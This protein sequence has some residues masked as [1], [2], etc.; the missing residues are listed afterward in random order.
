LKSV[1]SAPGKVILFGEHFVVYGLKAVLASIDKRVTVTS[2][3]TDNDLVSINSILGKISIPRSKL[4]EEKKSTFRPFIYL[5]RKMI[6]NTDYNGGLEIT[7]DSDLP[8]GVGLG[9]SSACCVAAA[10][11]I[12]GLFENYSKERILKLAIE[13]EKTIFRNTSGADCTVSTFGGII[14]YDKK[15]GPSKIDSVPN[16]HLV[17][18]NSKIPHSTSKVVSK[19]ENFKKANE[20]LFSSLCDEVSKLIEDAKSALKTNDLISL[21]R[22]FTRNQEILEQIGV[23]NDKLRDMIKLANTTSYGSKI[24]GAGDGGCVITLTDN[25]NLEQTVENLQNKNLDCFPVKID[26][27]GLDTF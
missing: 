18:A 10:S 25:S 5:V 1:A 13:A 12:F 27:K 7:I 3:T 21:G 2:T 23:S 20:S 17:I 19:V 14:E 6:Q 26:C 11:S 8:P 15:T 4:Y 22:A 16:F 24:T 9:S